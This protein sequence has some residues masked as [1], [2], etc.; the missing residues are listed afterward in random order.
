M[1]RLRLLP[2]LVALAIVAVALAYCGRHSGDDQAARVY[3][4]SLDEAPT[5]LDPVHAATIYSNYVIRAAYD[6]LYR[7]EYL[8]RPY[9][10]APN[11]AA[12]MPEISSDGLVYT[13][14]IRHGV[15][16]VDDPAFPGGKGRE[17]T[18]RDVVFSLERH[19]DP[20]NHS[21]GAWLWRDRIVGLDAWGAAGAD[22]AAGV[23]GLRALDDYTL[24][25]ELARPYPQLPFTLT[26]GFAAVVPREAIER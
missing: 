9:Q 25:I 4:H 7:Y 15:R 26:Q 22:Y 23:P 14:P 19:F 1:S 13:I 20:A 6:T 17:L 10:L 5:S 11:L 3:L 21:E 2:A 16:F 18:A 12:A 24:R 8:A